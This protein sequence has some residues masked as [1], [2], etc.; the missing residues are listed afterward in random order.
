MELSSVNLQQWEKSDLLV[1]QKMLTQEL[2]RRNNQSKKEAMQKINAIC[3][4]MGVPMLEILGMTGLQRTGP[5]K[6][7]KVAIRYQHPQRKELI[8]TGR[9]R[10]PVWM[11]EWLEAGGTI[12]ELDLR[13]ASFNLTA[14]VQ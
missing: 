4:N 3:Q 9:G 11:R 5:K 10:Q 2:E 13:K 7:T 8:W 14:A 1:L 6:G 12:D